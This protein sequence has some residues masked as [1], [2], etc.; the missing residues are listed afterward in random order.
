MCLQVLLDCSTFILPD[1]A[2]VQKKKV[3]L[4]MFQSMYLQLLIILQCHQKYKLFQFPRNTSNL[5]HLDF[6]ML[7]GN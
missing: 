7:I 4:Q 5:L 1:D 2:K 6:Y 3:G